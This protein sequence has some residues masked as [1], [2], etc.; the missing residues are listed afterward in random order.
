MRAGLQHVI[1][2]NFLK[3]GFDFHSDSAALGC[4]LCGEERKN[5]AFSPA[6][7]ERSAA[8]RM[9]VERLCRESRGVGSA[10]LEFQAVAEQTAF[11]PA[12]VLELPNGDL[13]ST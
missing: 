13:P 4:H 2:H 10:A 12:C 7:G 5:A 8:V 11:L 3:W 1:L 6:F 9:W